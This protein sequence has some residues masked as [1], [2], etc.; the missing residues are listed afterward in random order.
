MKANYVPGSFHKKFY[1]SYASQMNRRAVSNISSS[2]NSYGSSIFSTKQAQTEGL[3]E[4]IVKKVAE[5]LQAE[6]QTKL[7]NAAGLQTLS[8]LGAFTDTSA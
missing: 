6:A 7:K 2:V 5:R 4:I 3:N 8:G 1:G